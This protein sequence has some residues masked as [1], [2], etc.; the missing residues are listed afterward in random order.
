MWPIVFQLLTYKGFLVA[1][2]T[3]V[4]LECGKENWVL[5]LSHSVSILTASLL[6]EIEEF[7]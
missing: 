5:G 7:V 1:S 6:H 2:L 4:L 3:I